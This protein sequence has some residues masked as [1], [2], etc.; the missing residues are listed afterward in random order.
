ML[1][2]TETAPRSSQI[3][4]ASR[5]SGATEPNN[6]MAHAYR[7]ILY[8]GMRQCPAAIDD[9]QLAGRLN[10]QYAP[11]AAYYLRQCPAAAAPAAPA[12]FFIKVR[13]VSFVLSCCMTESLPENAR[14]KSVPP[15]RSNAKHRMVRRG[16]QGMQSTAAEECG[17]GF[18]CLG[19]TLVHIAV[20]A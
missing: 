20:D 10:R 15:E 12:A 8:T 4:A 5:I 18:K 6:W 11:Y 3:R 19:R 2:S 7:G 1:M 16:S 9:L 14:I 13:R 17:P